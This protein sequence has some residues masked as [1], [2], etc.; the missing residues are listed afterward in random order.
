MPL[1]DVAEISADVRKHSQ[2][3]LINLSFLDEF[4]VSLKIYLYSKHILDS[5]PGVYA[6]FI[7]LSNWV[8][9]LST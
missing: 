5:P 4:V 2:V 1:H 8:N 6:P 3:V 7:Y 9:V